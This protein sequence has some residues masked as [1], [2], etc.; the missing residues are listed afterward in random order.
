MNNLYLH[1]A[2]IKDS[3]NVVRNHMTL[4]FKSNIYHTGKNIFKLATCNYLNALKFTFGSQHLHQ[5]RAMQKVTEDL[6][7]IIMIIV[8]EFYSVLV[9]IQ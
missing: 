6:H 2:D 8:V 9:E 1:V 4:T 5:V 7:C 3:L